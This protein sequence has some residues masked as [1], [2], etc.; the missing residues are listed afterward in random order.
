MYRLLMAVVLAGHCGAKASAVLSLR[1]WNLIA[2]LQTRYP[3]DRAKGKYE[4]YTS[5]RKYSFR[6]GTSK[7]RIYPSDEV[8]SLITEAYQLAVIVSKDC[9]RKVIDCLPDPIILNL[10]SGAWTPMKSQY[11]D[12]WLK[13]EFSRFKPG[14]EA[15]SMTALHKTYVRH[16]YQLM[17]ESRQNLVKLSKELNHSSTHY[18]AKYIELAPD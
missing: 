2:L 16:R 5:W 13:A 4:V 8:R 12:R 18:T 7:I 3:Q 10:L 9:Y 1:W 15:I 14:G 6:N 17:G 11:L